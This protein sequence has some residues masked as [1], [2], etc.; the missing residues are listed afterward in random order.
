MIRKWLKR[1]R[2]CWDIQ[3]YTYSV[4]KSFTK[5]DLETALQ[6][7]IPN[8][9][10]GRYLADH[11]TLKDKAVVIVYKNQKMYNE[12]ND[13]VV[14]LLRSRFCISGHPQQMQPEPSDYVN[15]PLHANRDRVIHH[16]EGSIRDSVLEK[17][18]SFDEDLLRLFKHLTSVSRITL[19]GLVA[20]SVYTFSLF[21]NCQENCGTIAVSVPIRLELQQK[22]H[23]VDKYAPDDTVIAES[24]ANQLMELSVDAVCDG[25]REDTNSSYVLD[26]WIKQRGV[27]FV[28]IIIVISY[29]RTTKQNGLKA[30]KHYIE[31]GN[32]LKHLD[33]EWTIQQQHGI[34]HAKGFQCPTCG[35]TSDKHSIFSYLR[36]F[37]EHKFHDAFFE[38]LKPF[39]EDY[40][41]GLSALPCKS[42]HEFYRGFSVP[43]NELKFATRKIPVTTRAHGFDPSL[44]Q[45]E[46]SQGDVIVLDKDTSHSSN[47]QTAERY[48]VPTDPQKGS[49]VFV[50]QE[51]AAVDIDPFSVIPFL[52]PMCREYEVILPAGSELMLLDKKTNEITRC[53]RYTFVHL[54][55]IN[56]ASV[57]QLSA[58]ISTL[59]GVGKG[60][61]YSI[62]RYINN[63]RKCFPERSFFS[64]QNFNR[65][66]QHF[67]R[68]QIYLDE[69]K[70]FTL[71]STSKTVKSQG[72]PPESCE[73]EHI[74]GDSDD[75][76]L[77]FPVLWPLIQHM[78]MMEHLPI[79]TEWAGSP[80]KI[81]PGGLVMRVGRYNSQLVYRFRDFF[82]K[83]SDPDDRE[84]AGI[85]DKWMLR[86]KT[87]PRSKVKQR[88]HLLD[89]GQPG[90]TKVDV[91]GNLII[92]FGFLDKCAVKL[93]DKMPDKKMFLLTLKRCPDMRFSTVHALPDEFEAWEDCEEYAFITFQLHA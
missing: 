55:D 9:K 79:D 29:D 11:C 23:S 31:K 30:L 70:R 91:N 13:N 71:G 58:L 62:P 51:P 7:F 6:R 26:S 48:A 10:S 28:E 49:T 3:V 41:V 82:P 16:M 65:F 24:D 27:K 85:I 52:A 57:S 75:L 18:R 40:Q 17:F 44:S 87:T 54:I 33:F 77:P 80:Q 74:I 35:F 32:V 4:S 36:L 45:V 8:L 43:H 63:F 92:N 2:K 47:R 89:K 66:L 68:D 56:R 37:R 88:L 20:V 61:S 38:L 19:E 42:D 84:T 53:S 21:A 64:L 81:W 78:R 60:L 34:E 46:L 59:Q 12:C 39:S 5:K 83:D 76:D 25:M 50:I 93:L 1:L 90:Q 14:R 15:V 69:S 73:S 72:M 86:N 22:A 67:G